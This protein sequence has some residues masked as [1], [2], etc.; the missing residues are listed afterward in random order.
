LSPPEIVLA[1][2]GRHMTRGGCRNW[3]AERVETVLRELGF[4][5]IESRTLTAGTLLVTAVKS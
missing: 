4:G 3:S 1:D 2:L 5:E